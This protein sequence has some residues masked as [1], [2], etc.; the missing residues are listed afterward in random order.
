MNTKNTKI[1]E[2][3]RTNK[4]S[5]AGGE[6][7]TG[8]VFVYLEVNFQAVAVDSYGVIWTSAV[9]TSA[10]AAKADVKMLME[11]EGVAFEIEWK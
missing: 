9:C 1:D 10:E 7:G 11:I 2:G 3:H 4:I 5:L 6:R 8:K